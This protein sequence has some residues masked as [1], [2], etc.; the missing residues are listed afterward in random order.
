MKI[1]WKKIR[2]FKGQ[3]E[4]RKNDTPENK[5]TTCFRSFFFNVW[6]KQKNKSIHFSFTLKSNDRV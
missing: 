1:E 5:K 6:R 4:R 3:W 2:T